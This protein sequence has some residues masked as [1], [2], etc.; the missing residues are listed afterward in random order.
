MQ[1][2]CYFD[3][4]KTATNDHRTTWPVIFQIIHD[5]IEV[6]NI[7]QAED[8]RRINTRQ[9]RTNRFS[10][11][12]EQK[13]IVGF[14]VFIAAGQRTQANDFGFAIDG[15]G[16]GATAYIHPITRLESVLGS[17][18]QLLALLDHAGDMIGQ[19]TIGKADKLTALDQNNL[20]RFVVTSNACRRSCT[21]GH[22]T[23][24][25]NFHCVSFLEYPVFNYRE[26][27]NQDVLLIH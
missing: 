5:A 3:A 6:G 14:I 8:A 15:N 9:F 12:R 26:Y 10:A 7:A 1:V 20:G 27:T 21:T 4:D 25:Y 2:F 11:G 16:L 19:A 23:H 13:F 17:Y 24:D 18:Q 22:T